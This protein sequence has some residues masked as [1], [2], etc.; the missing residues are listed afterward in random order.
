MLKQEVFTKIKLQ[1]TVWVSI[2]LG[3]L[4]FHFLT[5]CFAHVNIHITFRAF[6]LDI[7]CRCLSVITHHTHHTHKHTH[8]STKAQT[9][10]FPSKEEGY[11]STAGSVS[12]TRIWW[13]YKQRKKY[14]YSAVLDPFLQSTL[15]APTQADLWIHTA[16]HTRL[17]LS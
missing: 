9:P 7:W 17:A 16:V 8:T 10:A 5:T 3:L 15:G 12:T 6:F 11:S 4:L 1:T 13:R 2:N 14:P